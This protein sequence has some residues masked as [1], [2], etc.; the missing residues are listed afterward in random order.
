MIKTLNRLVYYILIYIYCYNVCKFS[1]HIVMRNAKQFKKV[2]KCTLLCICTVTSQFEIFQ[3]S[4]ADY[5]AALGNDNNGEHHMARYHKLGLTLLAEDKDL[6]GSHRY[7]VE[8]FL[9]EEQCQEMVD[10]ANVNNNKYRYN[11]L[12]IFSIRYDNL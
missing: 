7:L 6:K 10:F 5:E 11:V 1:V 12:F 2:K 8:G 4:N 3:D 9:K